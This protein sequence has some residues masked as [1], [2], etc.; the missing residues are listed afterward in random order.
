M[1]TIKGPDFTKKNKTALVMRF[2]DGDGGAFDL[3][4]YPP[5]KGTWDAV[6]AL[7]PVMDGLY[8]G[9]VD[10]EDFDM[11]AALDVVAKA[12]SSNSDFRRFSRSDLEDIGFDLEDIGTFIGAYIVFVAELVKEKN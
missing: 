11:D 2:P 3:S 12:M 9:D 6:S 8:S 10:P 5:T 1:A 7:A 4:V